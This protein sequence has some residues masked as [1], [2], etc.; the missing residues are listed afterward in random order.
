[1][2]QS[3]PALVISGLAKLCHLGGNNVFSQK[4][5]HVA[6]VWQA[7]LAEDGKLYQ[8]LER[9]GVYAEKLKD[10]ERTD[11]PGSYIWCNMRPATKRSGTPTM[12]KLEKWLA[13]HGI[14]IL[15]VLVFLS[16]HRWAPV[17]NHSYYDAT[18][19]AFYTH[20]P[21]FCCWTPCE[22]Y[23]IHD[24]CHQTTFIT[25]VLGGQTLSWHDHPRPDQGSYIEPEPD[26]VYANPKGGHS[27]F[28]YR[29]SDKKWVCATC[30]DC[31]NHPAQTSMDRHKCRPQ[32]VARHVS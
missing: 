21:W 7:T 22:G 13:T 5:F 11:R 6:P 28:K 17:R 19:K 24:R 23:S 1:M 4:E 15:P 29:A 30:A 16:R 2:F 12:Q 3:S 26:T 8:K 20:K 25:L 27:S 9:V 18:H 14:C 10:C 31:Y 32:K